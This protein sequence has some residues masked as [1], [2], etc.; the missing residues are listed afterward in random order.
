MIPSKSWGYLSH[1]EPC[2]EG[3]MIGLGREHRE[4]PRFQAWGLRALPT[5]LQHHSLLSPDD[6]LQP[7]FF[8]FNWNPSS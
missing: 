8:S 3:G 6:Q 5:P 7:C 4:V 2:L 1:Y